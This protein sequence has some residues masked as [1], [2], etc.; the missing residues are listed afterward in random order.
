MAWTAKAATAKSVMARVALPLGGAGKIVGLSG[1]LT[2][3]GWR[4]FYRMIPK[5]GN[6]FSDKIMRDQKA[7]IIQTKRANTPEKAQ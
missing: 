3:S 1:K 5:S 6:R 7:E 2:L 4:G